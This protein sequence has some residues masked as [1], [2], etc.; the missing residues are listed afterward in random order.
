MNLRNVSTSNPVFNGYFWDRS[1]SDRSKNIMTLGG[2]VLKSLFCLLLVSISATIVWKLFYD[3]ISITWFTSGGMLVAVACSILISV[4]HEWVKFLTIIY[5]IAKGF[6]VGGFS[7][8]V[9]Q[10]FP[11]LPFQALIMTIATFM[12]MLILYKSRIIVLTQKF[13]SVIIAVSSTIFII[14]LV[15]WILT[16]FGIT[17]SFLWSTSWTAI[18][19]NLVASIFAALS[20][21]L[22]FDYIDRY[23]GKAN[24]SYEWFAALG[25]LVT[26][27]WLY[28]EI[29]RLLK[30]LAIRF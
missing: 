24:K 3:G 30:K 28:I 23:I 8:F 2:V 29:L 7:V 16:L 17:V 10:K 4:K 9:H 15:S 21:L 25:F 12:I 27:I 20:L 6:L 14:Y 1:G 5:A 11:S 26:I 22:D 19:F 13:R 18:T